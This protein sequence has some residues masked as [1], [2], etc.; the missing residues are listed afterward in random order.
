MGKIL[1]GTTDLTMR[2]NLVT[3]GVTNLGGGAEGL[4]QARINRWISELRADLLND[5]T[6]V[7]ANQEL[8]DKTLEVVRA[9]QE[10]LTKFFED[11]AESV[12]R[13]FQGLSTLVTAPQRRHAVA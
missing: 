4:T 8:T 5:Q 1:A 11:A 13:E 2:F 10:S 9:V 12:S 6:E 3:S 7:T